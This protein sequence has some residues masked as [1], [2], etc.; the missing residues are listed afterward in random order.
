MFL[1]VF[2]RKELNIDIMSSLLDKN[3]FSTICRLCMDKLLPKNANVKRS[4]INMLEVIEEFT[5]I[6]VRKI[7]CSKRMM[8][9]ENDYM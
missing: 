6:K 8:I 5:T 7:L 2:G 1:F 3:Q 9:G 4:A